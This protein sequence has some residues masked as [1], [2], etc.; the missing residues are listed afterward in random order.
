MNDKTNK[1]INEN[2]Y[3]IS[4]AKSW[5]YQPPRNDTITKKKCANNGSLSAD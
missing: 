4:T 5:R 1:K 3:Q 2:F